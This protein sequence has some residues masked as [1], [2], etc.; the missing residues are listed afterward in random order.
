[1]AGLVK[2]PMRD[3]PE[4]DVIRKRGF[5]HEQRYLA[6]L[7]GRGRT[8]RRSSSTARSRTAATSLRAAAAATDRRDGRRAPT[9]STRRR[10]STARGAATP[11]SC[12]GSTI[13]D[14]PSRLGPVPLRGRR[15]QARPPRQG[16]RRPPD[17]L[18]RR[19]ARADPGRP[20]RVA[21]RRARRQRPGRRAAPRRRL[22]GLLPERTRPVPRRPRRRDGRVA[23]PPATTYPE[24]VEHCDVCRWAAECGEASSRRRPPQP[25]RRDL[26]AAAAARSA[27]RGIATLEALGDLPLPM[28]PQL[29]GVGEGALTRVR[30]QARIQLEGR[31]EPTIR[32]RAAPSARP[33]EPIEADRGLASL[34]AAVARRPVLRYRGRSVRLR[35]RARLPVRRARD[36]RHV[37]RLLVARRDGRVLARRRTARLRAPHRL[38]H[39]AARARPDDARLPLRAVRAD[40]AQAADGPLRDARGRGRPPAARRRDGRP[41]ARRPAVA[42][43]VGRELLDQEDGGVLRVRARD[44][45]ARR[46]V[47]HRRVRDS[48]SSSARASGPR[49]TTS[50]ASSA[51]TATT[52]SA[53]CGCATGSKTRRD[54]LAEHTGLEVPRPAPREDDAAGRPDRGAGTGPGA[55]RRG[56]PTRPSCPTDPARA[57]RRAARPLAARHSSSAGIGART[58]RC[59]GSSIG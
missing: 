41:P 31:R 21:A 56:W 12:S 8:G 7:A 37:P 24:P 23:F 44:R 26:G 17:L 19:P 32:V 22:H 53:T 43:R 1:M 4:L 6:D 40:R 18:V 54:E 28:A 15:H 47:E 36:R 9:S 16:Q 34:P 29:E 50:T 2:R 52:S 42:A 27:D 13:P 5:Q 59:G 14:R 55:R 25:R 57:D 10:S 46:R 30:E 39:G 58:S 48:G 20:A 45:P 35:R 38:H 3:D 11:T 51:T 33:G 49:P